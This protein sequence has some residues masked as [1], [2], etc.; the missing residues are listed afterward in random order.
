[1]LLILFANII[2][3]SCCQNE[4]TRKSHGQGTW[5]PKN[6]ILPS[7]SI[8]MTAHVWVPDLSLSCGPFFS[9]LNTSSFLMWGLCTSWLCLSFLTMLGSL[10]FILRFHDTPF[11]PRYALLAPYTFLSLSM[12]QFVI[13][14]Y[15][16]IV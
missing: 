6:H 8:I 4:V 5:R 2:S 3:V 1:M 14:L 9:F 11:P 15:G 16:L 10:V 7:H 13:F 12:T